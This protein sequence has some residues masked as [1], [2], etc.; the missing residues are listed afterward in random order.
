MESFRSNIKYE[1]KKYL[2]AL[3][4]IA[5]TGLVFNMDMKIKRL[6]ARVESINATMGSIEGIVSGSDYTLSNI[7]KR[8][9]TLEKT[10]TIISKK[11][12]R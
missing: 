11:I 12:R 3:W 6:V 5:I 1:W 4:M 9:A 10:V 7:E 8:I 2:V